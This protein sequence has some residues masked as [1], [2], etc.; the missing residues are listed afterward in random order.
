VLCPF[1]AFPEKLALY[2]EQPER[3]AVFFLRFSVVG[4][5]RPQDCPGVG[6]VELAKPFKPLVD[7]HVVDQEINGAVDGDAESD[8]KQP[9]IIRKRAGHDAGDARYGKNQEKPVVSFPE[10]AAFV[11][12]LV[13]IFVPIPQKTVHDVFVRKPGDELHAEGGSKCDEQVDQHFLSVMNDE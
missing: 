4:A 13:V 9:M 12:G 5:M 2:D 1:A 10:T 7:V 3:F 8:V 6:A 11:V